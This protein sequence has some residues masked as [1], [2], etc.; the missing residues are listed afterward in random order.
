MTYVTCRQT[1]KNRD[2]LRNP[3][4]GNRVWATFTF[5]TVHCLLHAVVYWGVYAGIRRIPTS[6]FFLT[7]IL[8]TVIINKQGT[9]R[10]FA[11]P[12][13]VYPPPFLAIHHWL[14]AFF[15]TRLLIQSWCDITGNRVGTVIER[16]RWDELFYQANFMSE[17]CWAAI[18]TYGEK[19]KKTRRVVLSEL[20]LT[21]YLVS[22]SSTVVDNFSFQ[23]LTY[24]T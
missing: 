1:A 2:Q 14:H 17:Y 8:T 21:K 22:N 3:M 11:T 4:L 18:I 23:M 5:F 7:A 6:G 24:L 20:S 16:W 10:P 19:F 15:A 13:F 9:F 12:L